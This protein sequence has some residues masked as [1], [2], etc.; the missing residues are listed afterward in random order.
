MSSPH[1]SFSSNRRATATSC[2]PR[3]RGDDDDGDDDDN[4]RE[5]RGARR[6]LRLLQCGRRAQGAERSQ[7]CQPVNSARRHYASQCLLCPERLDRKILL[8]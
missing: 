4:D 7:K 6:R 1:R 3:A 8:T 2:F 5:S